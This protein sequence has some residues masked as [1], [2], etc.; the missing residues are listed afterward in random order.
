MQ[1][2]S[3]YCDSF[4]SGSGSF[5]LPAFASTS[6]FVK[7][8]ETEKGAEGVRCV[9]APQHRRFGKIFPYVGETMGVTIFRAV[10]VE[11]LNGF[12]CMKFDVT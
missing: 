5:F 11:D 8:A 3:L 10:P 6:C 2:S 7:S 4:H 9:G 1:G 12:R